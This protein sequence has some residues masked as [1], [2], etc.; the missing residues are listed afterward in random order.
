MEAVHGDFRDSTCTYSSHVLLPLIRVCIF[1]HYG[2]SLGA[3]HC[4]I[5]HHP[6]MAFFGGFTAG[7]M[8]FGERC[9]YHVFRGLT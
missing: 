5:V 1:F 3:C 6:L 7:Y 4:S 8:F 9:T 2:S